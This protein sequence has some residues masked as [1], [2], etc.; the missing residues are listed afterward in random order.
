MSIAAI[1]ADR[2]VLELKMYFRERDSVVFSFL[3]PVVMLSLFAAVFGDSF[4]SEAAPSVP[5]S[6]SCRAWSPAASC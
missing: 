3:F 4:E 2:T 5:P 6:S 1:A